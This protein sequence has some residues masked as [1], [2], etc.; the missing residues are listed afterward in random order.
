[1]TIETKK[2]KR[3]RSFEVED[4]LYEQLQERAKAMRVPVA[5]HIREAIRRYVAKKSDDDEPGAQPGSVAASP[6]DGGGA[7]CDETR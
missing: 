1:M 6:P 2:T 5:W 4:E 7:T 3:T